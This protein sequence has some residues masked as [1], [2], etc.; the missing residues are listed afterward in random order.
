MPPTQHVNHGI[1]LTERKSAQ[2]GTREIMESQPSDLDLESDGSDDHEDTTRSTNIDRHD[3][4]RMGKRWPA[5]DEP[6]TPLTMVRPG[7]QQVLVRHFR[8]MAT[9]SFVAMA[10]SVWEFGI[11]SMNQGLIDGGRAGLIWSTVVHAVGFVPIVLSMAEMSSIAP[12]AGSQYHWVSEFAHPRW[13]KVLS[14]YTGW[15]S[16]MAW[17]AGNAVGVFLTGTLIQTIILENNNDYAFPS[18]HGSLLVMSNIVFTVAANILLTR[19]IP[20]VQTAFFVLHILAFFAVLVPI[21]VNAPKASAS[22]VFTGF[23]NTGG[24][25]STGF[26]VLAGQ[27]SAIYMMCGTD[28]VSTTSSGNLISVLTHFYRHQI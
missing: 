18:W 27:L 24:W 14:Y 6:S 16:T 20:R 21:C 13:Q 22:E 17:Q 12:T 19:Y 8:P 9:F 4:E 10:T 25:S 26:A 2:F 3:M 7:K 28:S 23:A 1:E 15:I 5:Y 11:F